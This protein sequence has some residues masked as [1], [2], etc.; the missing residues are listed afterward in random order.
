MT[1]K[2]VK[3]LSM[4]KS[5]SLFLLLLLCW[6]YSVAQDAFI[7]RWNTG[8]G[9]T[10]KFPGIGSNYTIVVKNGAGV[11]LQ[12]ITTATGTITTPYTISSLNSN[13]TYT[14]EASPGSGTL[15][16]F[17]ATSST[18]IT[19][20]TEVKQWGDIAWLSMR[21]AFRGATNLQVTAT[22][23]P[24]L[25]A[26][27][28]YMFWDCPA[29]T[30]NPSFNNWSTNTVTHMDGMFGNASN[31]N[32][33]ISNWQ[34][35][36]VVTM[37]AM[38]L[39]ATAFNQPVN[40]NSV[41][42]AWNTGNVTDMEQL[43]C[44]ATVFNQ[45]VGNW[46]TSAVTT[47]QSMFE[48]AAAFN[49]PINYNSVTGAWN[50]G[51]VTS[52]RQMFFGATSFNQPL[53][54]WQTGSLVDMHGMFAR[55]TSF[56][57][58]INYNS[59]S[60]AWNTGQVTTMS[61]VFYVATSFNQPLAGWNTANVT[62]MAD[63]FDSATVFNQPLNTWNTAAVTN[64]LGMFAYAG[65]FN[66]P[67]DT[68]NTGSVTT[69]YGMFGLAAA[70]DR[71]IG[72]WNLGSLTNATLMLSFS[73]LSC[74]N[75]TL[76]LQGWSQA[77]TTPSGIT[78]GADYRIYG[79]DAV[80][81]RNALTTTRSWTIS[82]DVYDPACIMTLPVTLVDFKARKQ[83]Q[84][85][86]LSWTTAAEQHN[87]GFYVER[88]SNGRDWTSIGFA[89]SKAPGGSSHYTIEYGLTDNTPAN[90]LNHYRLKQV[91]VDGKIQYSE[92]QIVRFDDLT[93][94]TLYPTLAA[95]AVTIQG[96]SG[97]ETISVYDVNGR[98]VIQQQ[99]KGSACVVD[100]SGLSGG[101]Y[102]VVI[103]GNTGKTITRKLIKN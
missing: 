99:A 97:R 6:G 14:L 22:D 3:Q 19:K 38:F 12:T 86:D 26:D 77:A 21:E 92:Y 54:N 2:I 73:G 46:N 27:I 59:A 5:T 35:Q 57:Q 15:D 18:D 44:G 37:R 83:D 90:G 85:V 1:Y 96:L 20:L 36:N 17:Y 88:S 50:T 68:W 29:L 4:K 78:L 40:Y 58:P 87:R 23:T 64:M 45:P 70:F 34:T 103:T 48:K 66:Q 32:A 28:G 52:M 91:D 76:T 11:T 98:K 71:N 63:M 81:S 31:F 75:Y 16:R 67:L 102:Q 93:A 56:N 101:M 30:G 49:Q 53:N 24:A 69:M 42:G 79:N 10:I 61:S 65:A 82:G 100:V 94:I 43:F 47:M 84:R 39:N 25:P 51:N 7:T 74:Q 62:T 95:G 72:M 9:T 89:G 41:T 60:G 8:S 33:P 13:T 55:A 80:V